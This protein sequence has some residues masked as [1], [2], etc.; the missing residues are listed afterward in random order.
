MKNTWL[1]KGLTIYSESLLI[2]NGYVLI[3]DGMI[4]EVGSSDSV[5]SSK[6]I[7]VVEFPA[8]FYLI[9]GMIDVHIHGA[10][11]ADVMDG[12]QESLNKMASVL[13][14]EGTTSF[15]ATTMTQKQ[16]LIEAALHNVSDYMDH[17][18]KEDQA[19]VL[20]IHLEGPFI[21]EKRAG[22]QPKDYILE[23]NLPLFQKWQNIAKNRI[24]L[25]TLAPERKEALSFIR[26]LKETGVVASIG[27]SDATYDEVAVGIQAGVSHV[28]HLFNG[29][30]GLHHREPGVV[31]AALLH[32]ELKTE[33][34]VDGI[35]IGPQMVR[36]AYQNKGSEGIVL[37]TDAMQAKC[38]GDGHYH[39]GGQ[40]V[41]VEKGEARLKDGT[42][43]GSILHMGDAI[44]NMMAFTSC[45]LE[46]IVIM[47][48]KNPAKQLGVYDRKGS[49][50]VGKE[51]D[52]VVLNENY[53]VI[54]TFCR[55]NLAFADEKSR[56]GG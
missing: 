15:L 26:Y 54:M 39:L 31:G 25:V 22:A 34:I 29:M 27:H 37:I 5:S 10:N 19:E 4:S 28:T 3:K 8:S 7:P 47:S 2:K 46:D 52:L 16:E 53:E 24:K 20:G 56:L 21:S 6:D 17:P 51:A 49:I 13:P 48:S 36:L 11:G 33:M 45:S 42:L 44:R 32:P 35:H 40:A 23:P 12:T 1:I 18:Q 14:R 30:R 9:P 43:A 55:G 50:T 38:L 41:T